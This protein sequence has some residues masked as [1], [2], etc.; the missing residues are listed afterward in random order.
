M[1]KAMFKRKNPFVRVVALLALSLPGA[2]ALP[3]CEA[4]QDRI[5]A[6]AQACL[7][8]A[9]PTQAPR[10][11][12]MVAGLT[13]T[14]SYAIRCSVHFVVEGVTGLRFAN[15]FQQIKSSTGTSDPLTLVLGDLVFATTA[16]TDGSVATLADC[17]ASGDPGLLQV[18]LLTSIG[19][20]VA[21]NSTPAPTPAA[22]G[23]LTA[24]QIKSAAQ[25]FTGSTAVLGDFT[26]QAN[27]SFCAVGSSLTANK[28]CLDLA[29]AISAGSSGGNPAIGTALL[30]LLAQ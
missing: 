20:Y 4:D 16:G 22:D 11:T 18:A 15:A 9:T 3:G 30:A 13:S 14:Q 19:T 1:L 12:A 25:T 29:S 5:L 27:A 2:L 21:V 17:K 28:V 7:D 26:V 23:S 10:C 6:D 8:Q 24:A